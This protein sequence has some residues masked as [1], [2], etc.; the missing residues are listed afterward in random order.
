MRVVAYCERQRLCTP[1]NPEPSCPCGR[2]RPK[3]NLVRVAQGVHRVRDGIEDR[4]GKRKADRGRR[5]CRRSAKWRATYRQSPRCSRRDRMHRGAEERGD[6]N[7]L[8]LCKRRWRR[9]KLAQE[10][11]D[12]HHVDNTRLQLGAKVSWRMANRAHPRCALGSRIAQP[13]QLRPNAGGDSE[14]SRRLGDREVLR[15]PGPRGAKAL[16]MA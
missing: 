4:V 8:V 7:R 9:N 11:E 12:G 14:V 5:K 10:L 13:V 3:N 2:A 16:G 1:P 15:R 6:D